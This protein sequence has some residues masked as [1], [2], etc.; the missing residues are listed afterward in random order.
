MI[1]AERRLRICLHPKILRSKFEFSALPEEF[2]DEA[3]L[4][5]VITLRPT[6]HRYLTLSIQPLI[7][8][9]VFLH[10]TDIPGSRPLEAVHLDAECLGDSPPDHIDVVSV[11]ACTPQNE[12]ANPYPHRTWKSAFKEA[13]HRAATDA[14]LSRH[15]FA[16]FVLS[17]FGRD[18]TD[19][20][21]GLSGAFYPKGPTTSFP[22]SIT[23]SCYGIEPGAD[24]GRWSKP[25]EDYSKWEKL[26]GHIASINP[27]YGAT[28]PVVR[29]F[30]FTFATLPRNHTSWLSQPA[31]G[32][33]RIR[34][35]DYDEGQ[36]I[37]FGDPTDE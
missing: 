29:I 34:I 3:S 14:N 12:A 21:A 11:A 18:P 8:S 33:C 16:T 24:D 9:D 1:D 2:M 36:S 4:L 28:D 6:D 32:K 37:V 10:N 19:K 20:P 15:H 35:G 7:C 13:F 26:F 30:G 22:K 27:Y 5:T 25:F 23:I 17:N 31:I